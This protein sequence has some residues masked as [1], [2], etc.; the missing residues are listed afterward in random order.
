VYG[1]LFEVTLK[2]MTL[3]HD[4]ITRRLEIKNL[5][6]NQKRPCLHYQVCVSVCCACDCIDACICVRAL[7]SSIFPRDHHAS[8]YIEWPDHGVPSGAQIF[9]G[10]VEQVCDD[11]DEC[12]VK[13]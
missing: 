10:L 9:L 5:K 7:V 8:Q 11:D 2:D 1:G 6:N 4:I 3:E 13:C 12:G